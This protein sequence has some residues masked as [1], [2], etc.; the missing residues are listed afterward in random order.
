MM[1]LFFGGNAGWFAVPAFIGS[2]VFLLRI[3]MLTV[4]GHGGD[5]HAGDLHLDSGHVGD[6][7][8]DP[9][10]AFKALSI[11]SIAAFLM[12]FGWVALGA[13][14][15]TGLHWGV[16]AVLGLAGGLAM[17]WLLGL[18]LKGMYDLQSSGN[19]D[20][21][22]AVGQEGDVYLTVPPRGE[23]RGQVRVTVQ[24]R[25]RIYNAV[26]EGEALPTSARVRITGVN[27]DNVLTVC[28]A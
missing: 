4:G 7:H 17:V 8:S 12:G 9:G 11:Q 22:K 1:D 3:I 26:T 15:G 27:E 14:R 10:E 23:G 18:A 5:F 20:V 24:A 28:S 25:Q 16:S 13:H 6:T 21:R 2:A 19:V